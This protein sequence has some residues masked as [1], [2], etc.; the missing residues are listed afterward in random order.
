MQRVRR[1]QKQRSFLNKSER[2][3]KRK[4][5][6]SK[7]DKLWSWRN[8]DKKTLSGISYYE[9]GWMKKLGGSSNWKTS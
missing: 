5:S 3:W 4:W 7:F 6:S 8:S 2:I 1:R 9:K